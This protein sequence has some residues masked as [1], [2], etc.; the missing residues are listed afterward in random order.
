MLLCNTSFNIIS[1][2]TLILGCIFF[3]LFFPNGEKMGAMAAL[4]RFLRPCSLS[5]V[6]ESAPK[7]P[8]CNKAA[9]KHKTDAPR[10]VLYFGLT[11]ICTPAKKNRKK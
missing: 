7:D 5:T 10:S 8:T 9:A 2:A 6:V 4:D 1:I 3:A 11:V